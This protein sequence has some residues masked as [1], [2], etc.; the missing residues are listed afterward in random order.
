MSVD[1]IS[2]LEHEVL[3]I[4][5][6]RQPGERALS[7]EHA[8]ALG[9]ISKH[10]PQGAF[11]WGHNSIKFAQYCGVISLGNLSLDILPKIYGKETEPGICRR[12]L[13]QLLAKARAIKIHKGESAYLS[14]Q[15]ETLLD[16]FIL[17]FCR[18]LNKELMQGMIR[19]YEKKNENL[20]V[21]RG[22]LVL[23]Q[24]LKQNLAH[25]ERLYC[26]YDVLSEN[27]L[28]N[29]VIKY[30]LRHLVRVA[31]GV[32]A[33]KRLA[34]LLMRFDE[35]D[36]VSVSLQMLDSLSF[37]RTTN[38]YKQV[39]EQCRWFIEGFYP[40]VVVGA[41]SCMT[42]LF[43]MN[44]LFESYVAAVFKKMVYADGKRLRVQGPQRYMVRRD[45]RD[46]QVFLMKP[47]MAFL[48]ENND[49]IAIADAKW[50][51]LDER[52]KKM[53]ISQA[54]LYQMASYAIRYDV[55]RLALIYPR[56]QL[57]NRPVEFQLQGAG[58]TLKIVPIDL[59][60]NEQI[61][62]NVWA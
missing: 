42:L 35:I 53:G 39:F 30:V 28:H 29:Q 7:G 61:D 16:L 48:D 44:K 5:S 57:L 10:L 17:Q 2:V 32:L 21:I 22:R 25:K 41:N 19:C 23:G 8:H 58:V 51:M 34:E 43:D 9:K 11:T 3:P 15:K 45:D 12:I 6:Q 36:D 56:Q 62:L 14:L 4:V 1:S 13:V 24:Q 49:L 18:L 59:V 31:T 33:K 52:E 55:D 40:D 38:R 47:D 60:V 54:D 20:N 37:D 27:T 50:K 26:Q 46:E